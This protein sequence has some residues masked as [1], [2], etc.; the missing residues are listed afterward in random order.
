MSERR[1]AMRCANVDFVAHHSI[2]ITASAARIWPWIINTDR[3]KQGARLILTNGAA[4]EPGGE[5]DAVLPPDSARSLYRVANVEVIPEVRR[6]IRLSSVDGS[7]IGFASWRLLEVGD[8]TKVEFDVYTSSLVEA[9]SPENVGE[10]RLAI[11][12]D[13]SQNDKRF[14]AELEALRALI[15]HQPTQRP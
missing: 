1:G 6:T 15:E 10:T 2:S 11:D 7:L 3:W 4:D 14:L 9:P 13:R 8:A 5:F 12:R